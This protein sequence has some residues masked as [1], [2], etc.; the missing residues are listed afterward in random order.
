ML[1]LQPVF[2]PLNFYGLTAWWPTD[3]A[4]FLDI[5]TGTEIS[6]FLDQSGNGNHTN[7]QGTSVARPAFT[8][9]VSN[10]LSAATFNGTSQTLTASLTSIVSRLNAFTIMVAFKYNGNKPAALINS[11]I[12]A[13]N[14]TVIYKDN[15]TSLISATYNGSTY[16]NTS[17]TFTDTASTHVVQ[18]VNTSSNVVTQFIDNILSAGSVIPSTSAS[19]SEFR[20][21][22]GTDGSRWGGAIMETLIYNRAL[23]TT[24]STADYGY[25][26]NKWG[27]A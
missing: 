21:G 17:A 13:S 2:T 7:T 25:L 5:P 12:S 22:G 8:S 11:N 3:Q 6:R 9:N 18:M 4:A 20:I 23:S 24:E 10:G 16:V 1:F 27:T 26:K 19:S 14:R 15:S